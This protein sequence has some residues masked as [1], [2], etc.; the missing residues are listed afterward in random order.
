MCAKKLL[1]F[2]CCI[3][4]WRSLDYSLTPLCHKIRNIFKFLSN[5]LYLLSANDCPRV[6]TRSLRNPA[7]VHERAQVR[8]NGNTHHQKGLLYI[9]SDW[10]K[11]LEVYQALLMHE[12][13]N[14]VFEEYTNR[15]N[16]RNGGKF[17]RS[18]ILLIYKRSATSGCIKARVFYRFKLTLKRGSINGVANL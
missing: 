16:A 1:G 14:S 7:V 3:S 4:C 10:R 2:S 9:S 18:Q 11:T 17:H 8:L 6:L 5:Y 13:D 15:Y 12:H